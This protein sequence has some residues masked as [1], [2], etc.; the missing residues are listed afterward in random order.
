MNFAC[1]LRNKSSE[2]EISEPAVGWNTFGAGRFL[3]PIG[4]TCRASQPPMRLGL[5][6]GEVLGG[7]FCCARSIAAEKYSSNLADVIARCSRHWAMLHCW[8][9]GF[10]FNCLSVNSAARARAA[11]LFFTASDTT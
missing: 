6:F 8:G 4:S 7:Y 5:Y 11:S 2:P 1:C 3:P 9:S 10:Q